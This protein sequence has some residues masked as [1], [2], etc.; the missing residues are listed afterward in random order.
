MMDCVNVFF[1]LSSVVSNDEKDDINDG[2][3]DTFYLLGIA[4]V[5]LLYGSIRLL[6]F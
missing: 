3:D 4:S 6:R 2:D 5:F 1:A